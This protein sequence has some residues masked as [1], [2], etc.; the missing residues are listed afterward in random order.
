VPQSCREGAEEEMNGEPNACAYC[1]KAEKLTR[2]HLYPKFLYEKIEGKFSGFNEA[3]DKVTS[4]ERVI[5]D[6]CSTCNNKILAK[7]D[8]YGAQYYKLNKLDHTF[9]D[10]EFTEIHY[11][12][13]F[14][15]RWVLKISFNSFRT[16][17]SSDNPFASLIPYILNGQRRPK[18]KFVRLYIELIRDHKLTA[19]ERPKVAKEFQQ[20]GYVPCHILVSGRAVNRICDV[21]CH[22]RHFQVNAHRFTLFIFPYRTKAS[23]ADRCVQIFKAQFPFSEC[24]DPELNKMR[25]RVSQRDILDIQTGLHVHPVER[26]REREHHLKSHREDS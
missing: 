3:A 20:T 19:E 1:R 15:L 24:V 16:V 25:L 18:A 5:K 9:L 23:E 11:E 14:L 12:Y 2:E 10:E 7:V 8:A 26:I 6:V 17:E 22:C 13:D 21:Y 4:G